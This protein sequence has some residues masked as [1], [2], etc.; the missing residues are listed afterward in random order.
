MKV[1]GNTVL[2]KILEISPNEIKYKKFDFQDGPTYVENKSSIR[3]VRFSN[4]LKEEFQAPAPVKETG[5]SVT[6]IDKSV[7]STEPASSGD[8]YDPNAGRSTYQSQG[9]MQPV[10]VK[11]L[12]Q[13]RKIGER[14]M[15][16]VL[17]RTQDKEIVMNIQNA[18]DAHKLQYIGF[19]AIPL[20]IG[21]LI[22]LASS[23]NAAGNVNEG[24]LAASGV[25]L[26]AAIAC[27]IASGIFKGKRNSSNRTAVKLYNE[28]Y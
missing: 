8:Y 1:S 11:Y 7:P 26:V 25:M 18:K 9:K 20:G 14:E 15:Q 2:A 6:V 22:A 19:A 17:M 12:Y 5:P 13:G 28:K 24:Y 10:G 23:V 16:N 21:S 4:G 3:Y 27:P